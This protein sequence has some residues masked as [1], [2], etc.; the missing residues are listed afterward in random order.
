MQITKEMSA[1]YEQNLYT[2]SVTGD[3]FTN[4]SDDWSYIYQ[5]VYITNVVLDNLPNIAK[6]IRM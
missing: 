1:I 4:P 2:W 6:Q 3:Q 5:P